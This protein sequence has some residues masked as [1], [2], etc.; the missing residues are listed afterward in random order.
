MNT[1]ALMHVSDVALQFVAADVNDNLGAFF[2]PHSG[3]GFR[4][5]PSVSDGEPLIGGNSAEVAWTYSGVHT[6]EFLGIAPTGVTVEISG[7]TVV[8]RTAGSFQV[9]RYVDWHHVLAQ[10][11]SLPGPAVS[12][13]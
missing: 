4:L 13:A 2:V 12:K 6:H 7:M 11:G 5:D 1:T 10:L 9:R 8:R 3:Q